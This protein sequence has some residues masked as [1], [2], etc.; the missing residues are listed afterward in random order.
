ML[1]LCTTKSVKSQH[2]HHVFF[3]V[4]SLVLSL[5][6]LSLC[7]VPSLPLGLLRFGL[8]IVGMRS[9]NVFRD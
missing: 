8:V 6:A 9:C 5:R 1:Y 3:F 2:L 4:F 7:S